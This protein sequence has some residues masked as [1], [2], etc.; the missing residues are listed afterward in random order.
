M[1]KLSGVRGED[2]GNCR[3]TEKKVRE[4][5]IRAHTERH[6][7]LAR[8]YNVHPTTITNI[9]GGLRWKHLN[10]KTTN[11]DGTPPSMQ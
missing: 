4:I 7:I 10:L 2:H 3:L 5:F 11:R 9:K 6:K 8:E 1:K